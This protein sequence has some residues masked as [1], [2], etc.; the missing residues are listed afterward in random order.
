MLE[1]IKKIKIE[2]IIL[3]ITFFICFITFIYLH[4]KFN[5]GLFFDQPATFTSVVGT[6]DEN[7]NGFKVV[8]DER[9]RFFTNFLVAVIFN[10]FFVVYRTVSAN[11]SFLTTVSLF[12]ASYYVVHI[13]A[14]LL[15]FLIAYR[16]KRYDIAVIGFLFYCLFSMPNML[17][18]IREI[19]ISI[20]LYFALL[21]Y[22]LSRTKLTK[23]D[24]I[25]ITLLLIYMFESVEQTLIF[26]LLLNIFTCLYTVYKKDENLM[27]KNYIGTVCFIVLLYIP[28]KLLLCY[29]H[30]VSGG[31]EEYIYSAKWFFISMPRNITLLLLFSIPVIIVCCLYKNRFGIKSFICLFIYYILSSLYIINKTHLIHDSTDE[32]SFFIGSIIFIF[33][34][35]FL[36]LITDFFDISIDKNNKAII[37]NLFT[38]ACIIGIFQLA[39]QIHGCFVFGQYVDYLKNLIKTTDEKIIQIPQ[40]DYDN[41]NFLRLYSGFGIIHQSALLNPDKTVD[42]IIVPSPCRKEDTRW[43]EENN[44]KYLEDREMSVLHTALYKDKHKKYI[45]V[46]EITK[47]VEEEEKQN[48][49]TDY[50]Q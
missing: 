29:S 15:N 49:L 43:H 34:I 17:W 24:V 27:F 32:C 9:V 19:H 5:E 45:D 36:I 8:F 40:E 13:C 3:S 10:I 23:I 50:V 22:F 21:S 42:K 26:A 44:T 4:I 41:N 39:W 20:L 38:I 47:Y 2:H 14:I 16:T 18:A 28:I 37:S 6:T 1:S 12:T 31:I 7:L 33:P 30:L 35:I 11:F 25:P 48:K 46:S